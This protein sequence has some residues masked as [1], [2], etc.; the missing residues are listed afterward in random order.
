MSVA[1]NLLPDVR[2]ARIRAQHYRHLVTGVA[3]AIWIVVGIVVGGL[4]IGIGTQKL[5]LSN[6]NSK[7][8][9]ETSQIQG[10]SGL[11]TALTAQQILQNLPGLYTGRTYFSKFMPLIA[12]AMPSTLDVSNVSTDASNNLTITGTATRSATGSSAYVVDQFYEAM[13]A[14]G[15]GTATGAN[16][17]AVSIPSVAVDATGKASF[18][19]SATVS[20]G[21]LHG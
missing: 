4:F 1:I 11:T 5:V 14:S 6:L 12:A 10:T 21:A 8:S 18:T 3:I 17:S 20:P 2:Q 9:N 16:F 19:L 7:I 13:K 15:Q